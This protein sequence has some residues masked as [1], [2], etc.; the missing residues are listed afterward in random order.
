MRIL[1]LILPLF[2]LAFGAGILF[3]W[4]FPGLPRGTGMREMLGFVT[5]LFGLYRGAAFLSAPPV[6]RRPYGGFREQIL[7][8]K[9]KTSTEDHESKD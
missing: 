9:D 5:L 6:P 3:G 8:E 4:I 2:F 1:H 7:G